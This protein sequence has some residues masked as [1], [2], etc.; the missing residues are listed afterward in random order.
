M[1]YYSQD[2]QQSATAATVA[3][4][5][6]KIVAAR[7]FVIGDN[8]VVAALTVP[9]YTKSERTALA[10]ELT[11]SI[12][13]AIGIAEEKVIL[14]FDLGIYRRIYEDMPPETCEKILRSLSG[15]KT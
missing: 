8:H 15:G 9:L 14:T 12:A 6:E 13:T 11:A 1:E 3:L 5:N 4:T 7:S 2:Y 10:D